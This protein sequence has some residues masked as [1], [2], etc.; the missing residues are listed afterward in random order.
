M[1][2]Q[3]T[4]PT[5]VLAAMVLL[6]EITQDLKT[7]RV[8]LKLLRRSWAT[9]SAG[10]QT[11]ALAAYSAS[12]RTGEFSALLSYMVGS[13]GEDTLE[14]NQMSLPFSERSPNT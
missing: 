9:S 2:G 11:A 12:L 13:G 14:A 8:G 4:N 10:L 1:T 7:V 6:D 3:S 5:D